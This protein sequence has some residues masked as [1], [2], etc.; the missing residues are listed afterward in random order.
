MAPRVADVGCETTRARR[1]HAALGARAPPGRARVYARLCECVLADW[2]ATH[3]RAF[4][5]GGEDGAAIDFV[6]CRDSVRRASDVGCTHSVRRDRDARRHDALDDLFEFFDLNRVHVAEWSR[7]CSSCRKTKD[8]RRD[9]AGDLRTCCVCLRDRK[10]NA[11][12]R[13]LRTRVAKAAAER[14]AS[15]V[16]VPDT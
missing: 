14:A 8:A 7:Y 6:V 9:F 10:E 2:A 4:P 3:G 11:R 16:S 5:D 15:R 12:K 13:R 1:A